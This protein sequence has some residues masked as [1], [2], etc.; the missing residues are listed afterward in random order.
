MSKPKHVS[1][2]SILM[3]FSARDGIIRNIKGD[4][5]GWLD[6]SG[7]GRHLVASGVD[8]GSL[9]RVKQAPRRLFRGKRRADR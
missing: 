3:H 6:K 4:V 2:R 1:N 7:R 5:L 9:V 8:L